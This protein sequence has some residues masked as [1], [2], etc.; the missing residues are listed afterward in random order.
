[1][2]GSDLLHLSRSLSLQVIFTSLDLVLHTEALLSA[3][4][5]LSAALSSHDVSLPEKETRARTEQRTV[6]SKS[7]QCNTHTRVNTHTHINTQWGV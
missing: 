4:N 2:V 6:S 1:M 3:V 7:G 5:F